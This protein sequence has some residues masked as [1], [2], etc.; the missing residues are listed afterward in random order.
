MD[1]SLSFPPSPPSHVGGPDGTSHPNCRPALPRL[2][3]GFP[4][5]AMCER[6]AEQGAREK[7]VG[8]GERERD[9]VVPCRSATMGVWRC[10]TRRCA[11]WPAV[12]RR[13]RTCGGRWRGPA[14][15]D[16]RCWG[17]DSRLAAALVGAGGT[18]PRS[19]TSWGPATP[20]SG[21]CTPWG[22]EVLRPGGPPAIGRGK[23]DR[24][25]S[26]ELGEEGWG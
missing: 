3:G 5:P 22:T 19:R 6:E 21:G 17:G 2:P 1:E 4:L 23:E 24:G 20:S 25:E 18:P 7:R 16:P 12:A 13:G 26:G 14:P 11:W 8:L 15:E 10:S 9:G